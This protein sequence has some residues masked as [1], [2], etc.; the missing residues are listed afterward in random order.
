[1]PLVT[2][3]MGPLWRMEILRGLLS[4][5]G[6]PAFIAD[7]NLKTIDPFATGALALDARLQVPEETVNEARTVLAEARAS[8]AEE[9]PS[10]P[11]VAS[12]AAELENL[13][14]RLRWAAVLVWMHPFVFVHGVKYLRALARG[15]PPPAANTLNLAVLGF[16]TMFWSAMLLLALRFGL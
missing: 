11:A 4:E 2:L 9:D 14:R 13:G 10:D 1:M 6:V 7:S 8:A 5:R 3:E 16:L 15:V 12:P